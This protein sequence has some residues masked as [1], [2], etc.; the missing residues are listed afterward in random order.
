MTINVHLSPPLVNP[1]VL[2]HASTGGG[3][4]ASQWTHQE[5]VVRCSCDF[6]GSYKVQLDALITLE[7][8]AVSF[9]RCQPLGGMV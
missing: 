5:M 4:M 6:F 3:G 9:S 2:N 7:M 1:L 8:M